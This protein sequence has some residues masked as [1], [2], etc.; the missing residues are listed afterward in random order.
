[1]TFRLSLYDNNVEPFLP[2][3]QKHCNRWKRIEI[4]GDK[5][6][7]I[8]QVLAFTTFSDLHI[9]EC[10]VVRMDD[11][12]FQPRLISNNLLTHTP[13]LT[14]LDVSSFLFLH[15]PPIDTLVNVALRPCYVTCHIL[16]GLARSPIEVL[17]LGL[18]AWGSFLSSPP[19][20][21]PSL[22]QL[23]V[24]QIDWVTLRDL[25]DVLVAPRLNDLA[26]MLDL[27]Q[28]TFAIDMEDSVALSHHLPSV[29]RLSITALCISAPMDFLRAL[30]FL[31]GWKFPGTTHFTTNFPMDYLSALQTPLLQTFFPEDFEEMGFIMTNTTSLPSSIPAML[32]PRLAHLRCSDTSMQYAP[33]SLSSIAQCRRHLG[34]PLASITCHFDQLSTQNIEQLKSNVGELYDWT[35]DEVD[36][37]DGT[38]SWGE[39]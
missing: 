21:Y 12:A 30:I 10:L 35:E 39:L 31:F 25:L 27:D 6:R 13:R 3:L 18:C 38:R 4:V 14:T 36:F 32:F 15:L 22:S 34:C 1:M 37:E 5:F 2:L 33:E 23:T 8:Q 11:N 17:K 7:L 24:E 26:I 20:N 28:Y 29:T 9:L 16:D 19:F